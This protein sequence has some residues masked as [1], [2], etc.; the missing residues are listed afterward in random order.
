MQ[1]WAEH[2][3][4][5]NGGWTARY[6][7]VE[8]GTWENRADQ[9]F[10]PVIRCKN[11]LASLVDHTFRTSDEEFVE[12]YDLDAF[13]TYL[14]GVS[15]LQVTARA[16]KAV[17][18]K[19]DSRGRRSAEVQKNKDVLLERSQKLLAGENAGNALIEDLRP[20]EP[21]QSV[22]KR[23][24]RQKEPEKPE[25]GAA[26]T[27]VKQEADAG[28]SSTATKSCSYR[29]G[30]PETI[31]TRKYVDGL[32]AQK[33][34]AVFTCLNQLIT[35]LEPY[36]PMPA[37]LRETLAVC[38]DK[39]SHVIENV[40][41]TSHANGKQLL[42]STL[43][44]GAV[45][46]M[47]DGQEF[48]VRLQK[49]SIYC[50]WLA[51]SLVPEEFDLFVQDTSGKKNPD[52]SVLSH[53]YMAWEDMVLSHWVATLRQAY[54]I[55]HIS[56]HFDGIRLAIEETDDDAAA[57][58]R[59]CEAAIAD[60]TSFHVKLREKQHDTVFGL[61]RRNTEKPAF[62]SGDIFVEPGN[63]IPH[64]MACL[65]AIPPEQRIKLEQAEDVPMFTDNSV[66]AE[67]ISNVLIC[68][69]ASLFLSCL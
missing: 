54:T 31:R 63:C 65:G 36:P 28:P 21:S 52:A 27:E 58:C 1:G 15:Y 39:R 22:P 53:L 17:G 3:Q 64:A 14:H 13:A 42:V 60:A 51:V 62:A 56:L 5:G 20:P 48:F 18:S 49:V 55:R 35:K 50:R 26:S 4:G 2:Q 9:S 34:H 67:H 40:V 45:P 69:I 16:L 68:S 41:R 29:Y 44:G 30:P 11:T 19:R 38:A 12:R 61:L 7:L 8:K 6:G 37:E 47:Y 57:V 59:K 46:Q 33:F 25:A 23:R 43:Y 32:G 24:R 10:M 66:A